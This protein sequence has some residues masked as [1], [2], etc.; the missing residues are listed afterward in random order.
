MEK[1]RQ[2]LNDRGETVAI[3]KCTKVMA[4]ELTP[5][6]LL[7]RYL[8]GSGLKTEI[9]QKL[10]NTQKCSKLAKAISNDRLKTLTALR[11]S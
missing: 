6:Q 7:R 8:A 1:T 2:C 11:Q 4:R 9:E 5:L 3:T 10:C